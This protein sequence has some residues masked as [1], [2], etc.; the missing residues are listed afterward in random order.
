MFNVWK[1]ASEWGMLTITESVGGIVICDVDG[2][3]HHIHTGLGNDNLN[4]TDEELADLYAKRTGRLLD[5]D[6]TTCI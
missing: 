3:E 2:N 4:W 5:S 1:I 6:T